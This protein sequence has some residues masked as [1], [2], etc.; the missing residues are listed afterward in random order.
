MV[1]HR[2]DDVRTAFGEQ[3]RQLMDERDLSLRRVAKLVSYD[4]G[5][6]SKVM[7][8]HKPPTPHLAADLDRVLEAQGALI[9]VTAPALPDDADLAQLE[10]LRQE[11]GDV[12]CEGSMAEGSLDEWEQSV[13]QHGRATRDRPAGR[14]YADLTADLAELK[15]AVRRCH[16]AS[17]LRRLTR[18]TAQMSGLMYLTL[19]KLDKPNTSRRW[20]RTARIAAQESDDPATQSWVLAQEAYG[21]FYS[22]DLAGAITVAR[23]AQDTAGKTVCT[24]A[25]LAAALEARAHAGMGRRED[26][27]TVLGRVEDMVEHLDDESLVPSAFGYNEAQ[28]RFHEGNAYTLLSE[29]QDYPRSN[30]ERALQAQERAL[31]LCAPGDYTDWAMTRLDRASCLTVNGDITAGVLY[32]AETLADLT[33]H[34]R[35]GIITLRGREIVNA[36]NPGH[37]ALPIVRDLHDLLVETTK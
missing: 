2:E 8:G 22:G 5:Y 6:L 21:H 11:L 3:M 27:Q 16:T 32:M 37:R 24:G 28:F 20:A 33:E 12:L 34:Q 13:L 14:I 1:S 23:H 19:V 31:E 9:A 10:L 17:A 26:V 30:L 35:E 36:L 25:P 18:M 15:R 7:N 29:R 4:P